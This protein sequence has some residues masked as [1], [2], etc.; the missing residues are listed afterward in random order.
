ML[1][2]STS[3][4]RAAMAR[5]AAADA[6]AGAPPGV[7]PEGSSL[8]HTM[9]LERALGV[10]WQSLA[11]SGPSKN[12]A[13]CSGSCQVAASLQ[14]MATGVWTWSAAVAAPARLLRHCQACTVP[15]LA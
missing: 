8:G 6:A 7:P 11:P 1:P 3:T 15:R 13:S 14:R 2:K 9:G 10:P 5:A 12:A 4:G